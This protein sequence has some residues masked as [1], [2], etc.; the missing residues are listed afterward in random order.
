MGPSTRAAWGLRILSLPQLIFRV[1]DGQKL[2]S[3]ST[4]FL[5]CLYFLRVLIPLYFRNYYGFSDQKP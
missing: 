3:I 4:L 1:Q 2:T 5:V